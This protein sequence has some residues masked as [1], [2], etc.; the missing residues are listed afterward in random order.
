MM[1]LDK[2]YHDDLYKALRMHEISGERAGEVLAEVEAHV[3]ETGENPVEAFGKPREYARQVAAQLDPATGKPSTAKTVVT[4]VVIA[5]LAM[6]GPNFIGDGLY[7]GAEGVPFTVRDV[8]AQPLL[9][10]FVVTGVLLAFRAYTASAHNKL[11]AG[12]A[13]AAAV[14]FLASQILCNKY[15]DDET[16]V[17]SAP[18]WLILALG[19]VFF[20]GVMTMLVQAIRRGRLRYPEKK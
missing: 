6:F 8:V 20:V 2:K 11:F 12:G 4:G 7:Y 10:I 18:S 5:A 15:L 1:T 13:V 14:A 19:V 3:I 17:F 16:P 9:L